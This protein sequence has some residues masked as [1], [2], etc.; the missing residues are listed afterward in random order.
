MIGK[1]LLNKDALI[2]ELRSQN[3]ILRQ[4]L[5]QLYERMIVMAAST[6]HIRIPSDTEIVIE[7]SS[8][9]A[10]FDEEQPDLRIGN[11]GAGV[12]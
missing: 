9:L 3:E 1:W 11:K 5:K 6:P 12:A 10:T 7:A 2:E 8:P 4:E